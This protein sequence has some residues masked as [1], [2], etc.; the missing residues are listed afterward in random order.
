M[1]KNDPPGTGPTT[2]SQANQDTNAAAAATT[3]ASDT[4]CDSEQRLKHPLFYENKTFPLSHM[5]NLVFNIQEIQEEGLNQGELWDAL[6]TLIP[7]KRMFNPEAQYYPTFYMKLVRFLEERQIV[8]PDEY[9][10]LGRHAEG[11]SRAI[12]KRPLPSTWSSSVEEAGPSTPTCPPPAEIIRPVESTVDTPEPIRA[13]QPGSAGTDNHEGN[14]AAKIANN[15]ASRF[16]EKGNDS[17][18]QSS[19]TFKNFLTNT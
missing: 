10:K 6:I 3:T 11:I 2:R 16:R 8:L 19:R 4:V 12:Y 1:G 9:K 5:N 14:N 18:E 13:A 7:H 17:Q 15:I